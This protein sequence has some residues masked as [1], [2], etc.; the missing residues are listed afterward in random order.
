MIFRS[1]FATLFITLAIGLAA[2]ALANYAIDI[3]EIYNSPNAGFK[4]HI[5]DYVHKL[6]SSQSGLVKPDFSERYIKYEL[7]KNYDAKCYVTGS[8]HEMTINLD[9]MPA[10]IPHCK[11]LIN[12]A[13]SGGGFEDALIL[14][15]TLAGRR[16]D[17]LVII[18]LGPWFFKRNAASRWQDLGDAYTLARFHFFGDSMPPVRGSGK[19]EN[20]INGQYLARNLH[21]LMKSGISTTP[22]TII[23]IPSQDDAVLGPDGS[24][25]YSRTYVAKT[26]PRSETSECRDYQVSP[27]FVQERVDAEFEQA[28][29]IL[30]SK[31]KRVAL[32]LMPYHPGVY[33]CGNQTP[34]ALHATEETARRL[35]GRLGIPVWGGYDPRRHGMN[36]EDFYD[37][38]HVDANSLRKIRL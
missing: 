13:S 1:F 20:L 3:S 36:G 18:G 11:S 27:P 6:A 30:I 34:P 35:G 7:A 23:V 15:D 28:L 14:M 37:F 25:T 33:K 38:M 31:G 17:E 26:L 16:G 4:S 12:L 19:L 24:L 22:G 10:L 9:R 5:N 29:R 2:T 8:S 21:S 32:L